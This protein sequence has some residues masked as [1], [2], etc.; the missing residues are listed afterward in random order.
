MVNGNVA[1]R[2]ILLGFA[3]AYPNLPTYQNHTVGWGE[4]RTPTKKTIFVEPI[5]NGFYLTGIEKLLAT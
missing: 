4:V 2:Y 5:R 1:C 3:I